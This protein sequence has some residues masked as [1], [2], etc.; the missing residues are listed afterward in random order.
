VEPTAG[1]Q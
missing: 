1:E